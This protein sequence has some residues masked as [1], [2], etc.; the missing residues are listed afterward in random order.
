MAGILALY[1]AILQTSPAESPQ[2]PFG[3]PADRALSLIPSHFQPN[4]AWRWLAT[5]LSPPL[6]G[7]EPMANLLETFLSVAGAALA[8]VFGKAFIKLLLCLHREG[9]VE[10]KAGFSEKSRASQVK[11]ELLIEDWLK[12]GRPIPAEGRTLGRGD[13]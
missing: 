2:L 13:F 3:L 10:R 4:A 9:L 6:I 12:A 11:L 8:E 7:L 5:S 1:A